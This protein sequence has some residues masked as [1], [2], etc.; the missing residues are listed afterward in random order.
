MQHPINI[1]KYN[2]FVQ[3]TNFESMDMDSLKVKSM[4]FML[5]LHVLLE[6][7]GSSF[8]WVKL[9]GPFRKEC[10][11]IFL[12]FVHIPEWVVWN[13]LYNHIYGDYFLNLTV[14]TKHL[15]FCSTLWVLI[16]LIIL[17]SGHILKVLRISKLV[18][19]HTL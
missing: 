4:S 2:N 3:R 17:F 19:Y 1:E 12:Y 15:K 10:L 5:L 9:G 11:Y 6:M 14:T 18:K 7:S 13:T 8:S 16:H